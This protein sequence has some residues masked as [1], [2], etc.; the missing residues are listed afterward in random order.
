MTYEHG[1]GTRVG[2]GRRVDSGEAAGRSEPA[3]QRSPFSGSGHPRVALGARASFVRAWHSR[4]S[5]TR[6][7][8]DVGDLRDH[9]G[10][11]SNQLSL[12][13]AEC[14]RSKFLDG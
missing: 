7:A 14:S 1:D 12:V 9:R 13:P 10:R 3:P 5:G 6:R 2:E 11:L 4:G 8:L